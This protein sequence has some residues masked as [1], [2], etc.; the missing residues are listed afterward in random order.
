MDSNNVN[1]ELP[2]CLYHYTNIESL[3]HILKSQQI[4]FSRL[5]L[6][7]DMTE[8]QS[9]DA[10]DWKKYFF[11]SCWSN[12]PVESIP[13]W[14][15]YTKEMSGVRLKLPTSMFKFHTIN[16]DELPSGLSLVD[17]NIIPEDK[18]YSIKSLLPY[19]R[20]HGEDYF[21]MAPSFQESRWPCKINYT[22]DESLLNQEL[23]S[24][25]SKDDKTTLT[26]Y[27]IAK[28]KKECWAFQ[29]EWRFRIYCHSAPPRELMKTMP[30]EKYS[31]LM[32]KDMK[33]FSKG[34]SQKYFF[35]DLDPNALKNLEVV[36][37]P[38]AD[39]SQ[40]VIVNSLIEKYCPNVKLIESCL[41]GQ[42]RNHI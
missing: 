25:N 24:Y 33:S 42:I 21:V 23:I 18:K 14:H 17:K 6:V 41:T 22:D 27:E 10:V 37:G 20:L 16:P 15:M 3:A 5:D 9:N 38:K 34:V 11:I 29:K 7:D 39:E 31:V 2:E 13:L 1:R 32:L 12:D 8:G 40:K 4:R 26:P 19:D 35:L 28:Y 36:L 30:K